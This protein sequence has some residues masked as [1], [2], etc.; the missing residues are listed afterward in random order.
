MGE[1][2]RVSTWVEFLLPTTAGAL[3]W[4]D[5]PFFGKYPAIT[6]NHYGKGTVTYEGT[7][8]SDQI[9]ERVVRQ[10]LRAAGLEG[11]DQQLPAPVRTQ[12]GIN[13]Q[14]R[15]LRYLMNFSGTPQTFDYPYAGGTDILTGRPVAKAHSV[16]MPPWDLVIVKED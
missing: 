4:Y 9:Q 15:T 6:R 2:N 11:P 16:V 10:I 12:Q 8:L 3:A 5:H 13:A 14:G 1:A 7:M